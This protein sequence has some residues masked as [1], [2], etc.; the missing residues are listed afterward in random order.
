MEQIPL[1]HVRHRAGPPLRHRLWHAIAKTCFRF[2]IPNR[3]WTMPKVPGAQSF[4]AWTK[5]GNAIRGWCAWP[6]RTP[7]ATV[8]IVHGITR[9][10]HI[11]GIPRWGR[12]MLKAPAA[13]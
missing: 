5:E 11:D 8:L 6:T 10:L 7:R 12:L 3:S 2:V 1:R 9:Q 4:T 13:P